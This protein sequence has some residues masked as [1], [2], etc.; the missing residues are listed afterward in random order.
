MLHRTLKAQ[1]DLVTISF[2]RQYPWWLYPGS[3]DR[4]PGYGGY[5]EPGVNYLLDA[6]NPL[7]WL[8]ACQEFINHA[9][10]AVIIPLWTVFWVPSFGFI[11][12]YLMKR[13]IP[14]MFLCHNVS[15]H[16]PTSWKGAL[17]RKGALTR[18]LISQGGSFLVHSKA[19]ATALEAIV[20][21]ARIG[22]HPIP[23]FHQFPEAKNDFPRRAR[24]ELLFFGIIRPYKGLDVL[25][26]AMHHLKGEDVFLTV[27]GEWWRKN[28][29]VRKLISASGLQDQLEVVD[30][31]VPEQEVAEY[32]ARSDVVVLPYRS[33][34]AS[35][36]VPLAYHYEK[37]VIATD[38]GGLP[39]VV[40]D[41]VS[42]RLVPPENPV[43]LAGAIRE[44]LSTSPTSMR[45]GVTKVAER[46][47]WDGLV[48]CLLD[49]AQV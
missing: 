10:R 38:V 47:T 1:S 27:V 3:S 42:G 39:E 44:F 40:E 45:A 11:T 22:V 48:R 18:H 29:G 30:R 13:N 41:R 32:F 28:N 24:L 46:M 19:E 21:H 7:S 12:K 23:I 6:L 9:P 43:A 4:E 34:T 14:V 36:V 49:L 8:K 16:E 31:F 2:K 20:P 5:R 26:E 15:D 35:G 17:I 25:I 37:P 33:A